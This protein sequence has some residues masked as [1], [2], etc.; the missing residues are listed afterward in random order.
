MRGGDANGDEAVDQLQ[1]GEDLR[2]T[3]AE[4]GYIGCVDQVLGIELRQPF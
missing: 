4:A 3:A 2:A 1:R